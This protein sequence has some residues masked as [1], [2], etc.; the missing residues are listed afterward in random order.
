MKLILPSQKRA[1]GLIE[2]LEKMETEGR[3]PDPQKDKLVESAER[4]GSRKTLYYLREFIDAEGPEFYKGEVEQNDTLAEEAIRNLTNDNDS[5]NEAYAIIMSYA[6]Q[7]PEPKIIQRLGKGGKMPTIVNNKL[8]I[9][10]P[11]PMVWS[12]E[13]T[14]LL[15]VPFSIAFSPNTKKMSRV[16]DQAEK[17]SPHELK[18]AII[19]KLKKVKNKNESTIEEDL[20]AH[21]PKKEALESPSWLLSH[22]MIPED[23]IDILESIKE[24][25]T[26]LEIN[27]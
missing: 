16:I 3:L 2:I 19:Y 6:D 9:V 17:K 23:I 14:S 8:D 25:K 5:L 4:W 18:A 7:I 27:I 20:W 21:C 13:T 10:T 11:I 1:I 26:I 15:F 22:G 12:W 24:E